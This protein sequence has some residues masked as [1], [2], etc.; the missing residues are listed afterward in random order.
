[1]K[2]FVLLNLSL[3]TFCFFNLLQGATR[4]KGPGVVDKEYTFPGT[5]FFIKNRDPYNP[6][7]ARKW[8]IEAGKL[9]NEG[10]LRKALVLYEKF[11]KRRS[12]ATIKIKNSLVAIGP[13]SLF[14]A[15]I[16]REKKGDWQKA[17][18]HLRLV[19]Q[20][21]TNYDFERIAESLMRLAERLAKENLPRKW[22][23]VP[24]FR[25]GI[26][27]RVRLDEIANLA[28]GPRFAPRALMALAEI[29][30]N[31]NK[32]EEAVD[33]LERIVNL[34]PEN[35][36][37]EKA[38]FM[39]AKVYQDRVAGPAYD[40]GST[41]KALNFYEDYLILYATPP[42]RSPHES[43]EAYQLRLKEADER[44]SMAENGRNEMRQTLATSKLE[45]AQYVEKYGK[46]FLVRWR[47]L[48]NRPALQFYNEAI[49]SAPESE[50]ARLA[51]KKVAEL[52]A[53]D[54]Q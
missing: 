34:Y 44:S 45:V 30:L 46:Y 35:Y 10:S 26:Q 13:E 32:E 16:L 24:R 1:M 22:G 9:Q 50:A 14:R 18:E 41:L 33:A 54:E 42:P 20:A 3:F 21:Y 48:G 5:G 6:G 19:A 11:S 49:N 7:E 15:S 25:S 51:E 37:S 2:N 12:D 17:F 52:R 8:F 40:Q 29:A 53:K 36:Q 27:D 23:V 4:A 38:Y 43:K 47:E 31:D 28:R 39:L